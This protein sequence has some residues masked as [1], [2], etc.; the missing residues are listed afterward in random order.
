ML[1]VS[2]QIEPVEVDLTGSTQSITAILG[3]SD[4]TF[5]QAITVRADEDNLERVF[6]GKSTVTTSANR[7]GFLNPGDSFTIA[8]SNGRFSSSRL[9]IIGASGDKAYLTVFI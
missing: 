7:G 2:V 8:I 5:V 9:F 1:G 6:W 4:Q 3:L